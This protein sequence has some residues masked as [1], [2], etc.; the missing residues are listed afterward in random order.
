MKQTKLETK[1]SLNKN[2]EES[3]DQD[4]Y[5]HPPKGNVFFSSAIDNWLFSIP[6]FASIWSKNLGIKEDK[7]NCCLWGYFFSDPKSEMIIYGY[8]ISPFLLIPKTE[9]II[10]SLELE[11]K[12]QDLKSKYSSNLLIEICPEWLPISTTKFRAIFAKVS[13]PIISKSTRLPKML[14]PDSLDSS[15]AIPHNDLER[16]LYAGR[17]DESSHVVAYVAKMFAIPTN[18]FSQ[19]QSSNS[20]LDDQDSKCKDDEDDILLAKL[21]R[22]I[23]QQNFNHSIPKPTQNSLISN[24]DQHSDLD[25]NSEECNNPSDDEI[26][27]PEDFYFGINSLNQSS[28]IH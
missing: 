18:E 4:I 19:S 28:S 2:F 26:D 21:Q 13:D 7:L 24:C 6:K 23:K 12:P 14:Y 9:K 11:I 17:A 8:C 20:N 27:I 1:S 25:Q 5:F 3:A 10:T 15:K 22:S 16:D